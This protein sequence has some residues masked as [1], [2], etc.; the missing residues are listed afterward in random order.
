MPSSK[1]Q[2]AYDCGPYAMAVATALILGHDP[3][4]IQFHSAA[5]REHVRKCLISGQ[6]CVFPSN[7]EDLN[8]ICKK[9]SVTVCV[10]CSCRLPQQL[11]DDL[12]AALVDKAKERVKERK[13]KSV[14]KYQDEDLKRIDDVV[15][16]DE[17]EE[18][19]HRGC[20]MND[21]A[22]N[23]PEESDWACPACEKSN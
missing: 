7:D 19:Y 11:T 12:S 3:S 23:R 15:G 16:C 20:L 5:I 8:K 1:Q 22:F 14:P 21:D 18:W 4:N 2:N 10:Q 6:A 13:L 9:R 17:C